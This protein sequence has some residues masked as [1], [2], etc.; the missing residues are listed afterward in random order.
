MMLEALLG[1]K[2]RARLLAALFASADA[3]LHV[4]ELAR[5]CGGSI[6]SVQR[7]VERLE[8][9]G[10]VVSILDESG[11][12]QVSLVPDHPFAKPLAGLVATDY[13]AQ[14]RARAASIPKMEPRVAEA[15]GEYVDAIVTGFDPIRI[16]LFGSRARGTAEPDSDL[17]L[18]VVLDKLEDDHR[19]AVEI[20]TALG[21]RSIPVDVIPTDPKR[22]RNAR[23]LMASVVR[24]AVEDG[25]TLYERAAS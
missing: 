2:S 19:A 6:S 4:R 25:V 10:L 23:K 21:R 22:I 20:R 12:R 9:I 5:L 18:L 3:P 13:R 11:R 17:D 14:Y 15:L 1:S 8:A 24:E 16:V 7:D